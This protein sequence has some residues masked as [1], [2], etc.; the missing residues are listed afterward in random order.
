MTTVYRALHEHDAYPPEQ[1]CTVCGKPTGDY[2]QNV[3][4]CREH[5]MIG[6]WLETIRKRP[7]SKKAATKKRLETIRLEFESPTRES[8]WRKIGK[9]KLKEV[10][11]WLHDERLGRTQSPPEE[12]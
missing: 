6:R 1:T 4:L 12:S 8:T 7:E 5:S 3:T 11:R 2:R 10:R 9:R